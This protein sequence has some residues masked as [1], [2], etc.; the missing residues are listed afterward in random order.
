MLGRHR[1]LYGFPELNL[2]MVDDVG[3]LLD[4][5]RNIRQ[6]SGIWGIYIAGLVRAIA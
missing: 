3:R 1:Q 2:F 6:A 5:D 4:L